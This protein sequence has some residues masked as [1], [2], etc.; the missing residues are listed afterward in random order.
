MFDITTE[1]PSVSNHNKAICAAWK[2]KSKMT[3]GRAW[4]IR[5][6]Y[7]FH[8]CSLYILHI[9]C[10]CGHMHNMYFSTIHSLQVALN[11]NVLHK[12]SSIGLIIIHIHCI[13]S[14]GQLTLITQWA[15]GWSS[16][17]YTLTPSTFSHASVT[18]EWM[19]GGWCLD[20]PWWR[21]W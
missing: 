2:K 17:Q 6:R 3:W 1:T 21:L 5:N 12:P 8:L 16:C 14:L 9:Y 4:E 20:S 7:L 18:N 10:T 19:N 11:K 13:V 15:E